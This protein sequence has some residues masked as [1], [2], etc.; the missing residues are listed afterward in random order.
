MYDGTTFSN[1]PPPPQKKIAVKIN[2]GNFQHI[3]SFCYTNH[4]QNAYNIGHLHTKWD[5]S[6][7]SFK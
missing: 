2:K 1:C 5:A 6:S 7:I 3:H 4:H